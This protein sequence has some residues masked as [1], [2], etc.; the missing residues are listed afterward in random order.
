MSN[1]NTNNDDNNNNPPP[2]APPQ[3]MRAWV[4]TST[5]G[6]IE[7]NLQ[8]ISDAPLPFHPP[9]PQDAILV[10]V[11]YST[12]NPADYKFP[13]LGPFMRA[14]IPTPA[15]PGMDFSGV[16]AQVGHAI[17]TSYRVGDKVFGRIAPPSKHGSL[18]EYVLAQPSGCAAVPSGVPL[19]DA[20]TIG[21]AAQ[22]A[23]QCIAP[24]V[25]PGDKVF[26]NGGSGGTGTFGIQIAKALG[27]HVTATCSG[28]NVELCRSLGADEVIDYTAENVSEA[29]KAKGQVYQLVVD[30]VGTPADLHRAADQFLLPD[31]IFV[32]IGG[33]FTV[34]NFATLLSRGFLPSFLGGGK[35]KW[36]YLVTNNSHADLEQIARWMSEGKVK[37][38]IDEVF[39]YEDVPKAFEKLRTGRARGKIVIDCST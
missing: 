28:R 1:N 2:P 24:H 33:E 29:L 14:L 3:A 32:Q 7:K 30:N 38:V 23:Y 37:A 18:G 11:H 8:L 39:P 13:E 10:K 5:R 27:C 20:S 15:S 26:V 35:R 34:S 36:Q 22:T 17:T 19:Q 25:K 21:T 9:L 12:L 6:G 31:G 16:V 4:Y